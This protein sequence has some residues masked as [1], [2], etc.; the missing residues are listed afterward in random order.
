MHG[1]PPT[2]PKVVHLPLSDPRCNSDSCIAFQAAHNASQA[3]VSYAW[4]FEYGHWTTWYYIIVIFLFMLIFLHHSLSDR[5]PWSAQPGRPSVLNKIVASI[6][7]VSYRRYSGPIAD[8]LSLPSVGM[9]IFFLGA[10]IFATVATFAVRPYYRD[11]RGYGSPPLGVR[12]G[13]MAIALTPIIVALSGKVNLVTMLTG[14]GYE[15]LNVVHR[16]LSYICLGLSVVHTIPFLVAP[17][18]D[19]GAKQLHKQFYKPGGLE[20]KDPAFSLSAFS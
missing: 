12:T 13:L 8:K 1:G 4:Q 16:W 7:C 14:I 11:H 3:A 19:G 5:R 18:R 20:V 15:K 6:R 17:Y 10:I 2:D 9:Q